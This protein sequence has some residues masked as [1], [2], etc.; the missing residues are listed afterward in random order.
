MK[1]YNPF[2]PHIVED[3]LGS[4]Y[5]RKLSISMLIPGWV[6]MSYRGTFSPEWIDPWPFTS[7]EAAERTVRAN[8]S[9]RDEEK[10]IEKKRHTITFVKMLPGR[11]EA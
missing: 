6:Y 9:R 1:F 3:G 11:D 10:R 2:K 7:K 8:R 4:F 5:V